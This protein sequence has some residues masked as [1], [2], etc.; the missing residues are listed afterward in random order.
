MLPCLEAVLNYPAKSLFMGER[1]EED[2][3]EAPLF[4]R[5]L[6]QEWPWASEFCRCDTQSHAE[7]S[8][9]LPSIRGQQVSSA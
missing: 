9:L 7:R 1:G 3:R 6:T 4:Y 2:R 5:G 8:G